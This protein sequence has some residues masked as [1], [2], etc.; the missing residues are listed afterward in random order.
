LGTSGLRTAELL[1][2]AEEQLEGGGETLPAVVEQDE[3]RYTTLN[4]TSG[5][6]IQAPAM[7]CNVFV[8]NIWKAGGLFGDVADEMQVCG[9]Y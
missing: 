5:E 9:Y 8:C 7:V 3:W 6:V 4:I 2:L 1:Q